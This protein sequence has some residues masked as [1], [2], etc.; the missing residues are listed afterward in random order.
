MIFFAN[1]HDVIDPARVP[2]G[3]HGRTG[4]NSSAGCLVVTP[5]IWLYQT[6]LS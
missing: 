4:A 6:I 2:E 1:V 5:A 3:V